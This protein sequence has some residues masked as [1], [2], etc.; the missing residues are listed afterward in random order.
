MSDIEEIV[1]EAKK[2]GKFN[3]VDVVKDRGY[4]KD[5]INVFIDENVAFRIA[6][7]NEA[8]NSISNKMDSAGADKKTLDKLLKQHEEI[9]NT[10]QKLL[11]EMG[12]AKYVFHLTGISEGSRQDLFDKAVKKFPIKT[13]TKMNQVTGE[14]EE[15]EVENVERDRYFTSLLW[16]AG[17]SKI[18]SPDGEEQ[19]GITFEEA[20]ELRR[21]LPLASLTT[22]TEGLEKMRAATALFM[23]SVNEDFL[24][25]S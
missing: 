11:D 21:I 17:I 5:E 25:K 4:P 19:E 20:D 3:I 15:K 18:V 22:I 2:P 8:I 9:L 24:A 6:E 14:M 23:M 16:E 10:R 7:I 1:N 13:V 12:E